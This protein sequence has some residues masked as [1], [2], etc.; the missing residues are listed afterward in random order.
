[1]TTLTISEDAQNAPHISFIKD[2]NLAFAKCDTDFIRNAF[3]DDARW[4]MVGEQRWEGKDQIAAALEGMSDGEASELVIELILSEGNR[5]VSN[6]SLVY[7]DG[8]SIAYCDVYTFSGEGDDMKI[9]SLK[10]YAIEL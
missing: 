4:E 7:P 5:C 2:F 6:G 1:M 8:R 10:A 3:T 9:Q